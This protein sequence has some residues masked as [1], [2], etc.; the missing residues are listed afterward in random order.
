MRDKSNGGTLSVDSYMKLNSDSEPEF[1]VSGNTLLRY[2]AEVY[3]VFAGWKKENKKATTP[4][5]QRD[6]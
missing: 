6:I 5:L 1:T 2:K 4:T 3:Y